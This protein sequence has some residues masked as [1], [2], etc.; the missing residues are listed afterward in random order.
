MVID[1]LEGVPMHKRAAMRDPRDPAKERA[2]AAAAATAAAA[3]AAATGKDAKGGA[4][5]K[6]GGG[7]IGQPQFSYLDLVSSVS[8]SDNEE[9]KVFF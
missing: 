4:R 3:A 8:P 1:E 9:K 2:A 7:R 5:A 6:Q